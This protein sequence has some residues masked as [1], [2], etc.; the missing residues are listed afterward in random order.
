MLLQGLRA[1]MAVA[2]AVTVLAHC[3]TAAF[4]PAD[5]CHIYLILHSPGR[6]C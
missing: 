2:R 4:S 3:E 6:G 5:V 1:E